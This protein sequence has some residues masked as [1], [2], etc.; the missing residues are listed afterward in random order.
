MIFLSLL[1]WYDIHVHVPNVHVQ[2]T[3]YVYLYNVQKP[4]S[5][6]L[7]TFEIQNYTCIHSMYVWKC[8][9]VWK[10]NIKNNALNLR[11]SL[12][13]TLKSFVGRIFLCDYMYTCIFH[14]FQ[15]YIVYLTGI[16]LPRVNL[17]CWKEDSWPR[18]TCHKFDCVFTNTVQ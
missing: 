15:L 8:M 9:Y 7:N 14:E 11:K 17:L 18:N 3:L 2:C 1:Y 16:L 4:I 6:V 10:I 13:I 5:A 12:V